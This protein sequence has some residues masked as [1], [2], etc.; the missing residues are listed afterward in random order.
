MF[1]LY[2]DDTLQWHL[3]T[4]S[5]ETLEKVLYTLFHVVTMYCIYDLTLTL[6][7]YLATVPFFNLL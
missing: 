7:V 1:S 4:R 5:V 6:L 3:G 2:L